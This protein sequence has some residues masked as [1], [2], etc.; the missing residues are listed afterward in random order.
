[1][2]P[3]TPMP[4]LEQIKSESS[5]RSQRIGKILSTAFTQTS[6][7]LKEGYTVVRPLAAD[8]SAT[9]FEKLK[10]TSYQAA[11]SFQDAW[12]QGADSTSTWERWQRVLKV[13]TT[14]LRNTLTPPVKQQAAR[15]D[16]PVW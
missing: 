6:V 11:H 10:Q 3:S 8:M 5:T 2:N 7:E 15:V 12:R 9:A 16:K 13:V 1:M 4:K 14:A